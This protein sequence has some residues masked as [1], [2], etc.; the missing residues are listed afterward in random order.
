MKTA[1]QDAGSLKQRDIGRETGI[2]PDLRVRA[3]RAEGRGDGPAEIDPDRRV[4][5]ADER[6]AYEI[7]TRNESLEGD[8]HPVTGVPFERKTVEDADGNEVT[9]VFPVFDSVFDAPLPEGLLQSSDREQF[10]ACNGQLRDAVDKDPDLAEKFTPEELEQIRNGET[11][12][13]YTWHHTEEKGRMQLVDA[14]VHA[15][16]G[17]TGGRVIWGGGEENRY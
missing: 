11:P 2:D 5:G 12:D 1:L 13:G 10:D 9:G 16:T 15:Q 4:E 7:H 17:H 8:R 6:I 14:D 3:E